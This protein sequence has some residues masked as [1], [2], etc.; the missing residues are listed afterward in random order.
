MSKLKKINF[1]AVKILFFIRCRHIGYSDDDLKINSLYIML[2]KKIAYVIS[3]DGKTK[4]MYFLIKHYYLLNKYNDIWKN[5]S[6]IKGKEFD[7]KTVY[8]KKFI[9]TKIK[10]Y[11]D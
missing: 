7:N 4:W 11:G 6:N 9:K 3:Y 8:N 1:T 2:P 5:V 10:S